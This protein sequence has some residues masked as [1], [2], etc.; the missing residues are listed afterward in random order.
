MVCLRRYHQ[1]VVVVVVK[2]I[3]MCLNDLMYRKY[4]T[5]KNNPIKVESI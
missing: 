2:C 1:Y 5:K 3:S 4:F